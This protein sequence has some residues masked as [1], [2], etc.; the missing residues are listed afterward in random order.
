MLRHMI[1]TDEQLIE[2][3]DAF[4]KRTDMAPT[5]FGLETLGDGALL[6]N[7]REGR[8]LSLRNA[9]KVLTFMADYPAKQAAA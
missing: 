4:L 7:L 3:I 1:I 5:R 6:K 8:S 2:Q 9:Q